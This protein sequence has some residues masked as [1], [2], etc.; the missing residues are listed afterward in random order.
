M[1]RLLILKIFGTLIQEI[2]STRKNNQQS[3]G[4]GDN[5]F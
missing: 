2:V 1:L 3:G 5:S 4:D